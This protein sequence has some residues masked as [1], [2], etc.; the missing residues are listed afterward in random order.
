MSTK[1]NKE[2]IEEFL[3]HSEIE[4][5]PPVERNNQTISVGKMK[6][7]PIDLISLG[8][9]IDT[10]GEKQVRKKKKK[11]PDMSDINKN[12]IPESLHGIINI[13]KEDK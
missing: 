8:E 7:Q 11:I 4:I 12:L 10:Y 2:L 9:A 1:T 3:K 5:I 13:Y 6:V